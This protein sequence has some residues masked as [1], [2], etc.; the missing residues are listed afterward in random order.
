MAR[1][2]NRKRF[3]KPGKFGTD[4]PFDSDKHFAYQ[5]L[6]FVLVTL[7]KAIA[8]IVP[9]MTEIIYQNL[10]KQTQWG[11]PSVHL[12]EYPNFKNNTKDAE[13][14]SAIRTAM[15]ISSLGRGA[16]SQASIKVRQP[17]DEIKVIVPEKININLIKEIKL[18]VKEE[19]NIKKVIFLQNHGELS[20]YMDFK[21]EPDLAILGPEYG[22]NI[23][24]IKTAIEE[25]DSTLLFSSIQEESEVKIG[26]FSIA[27]AALKTS[28]VDKNG[29]SSKSDLGYTVVLNT[30]I[31]NELYLEGIAR[32]FVHT[33]QNLRREAELEISDKITVMYSGSDLIDTVI[34]KHDKY[35]KS[36]TLCKKIEKLDQL[37]QVARTTVSI[38]EEKIS[39]GLEI[40][41]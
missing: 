16:R 21:I 3:W 12:E 40:I 24:E 29:Y 33:I 31:S 35:I 15:K 36:E 28:T 18:E 20:A 30:D 5:S 39:L 2:N 38:G 4:A 25:S 8:P 34:A 41:E 11:K 10:T 17:L 32:E 27:S 37:P 7:A 14:Q 22:K 9:F 19:L 26:K 13:L 1:E 6:Y 23:N